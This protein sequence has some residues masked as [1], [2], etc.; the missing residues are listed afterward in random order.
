ML[1]D[2]KT[3]VFCVTALIVLPALSNGQSQNSGER[4]NIVL[5]NLDDADS[6]LFLPEMLAAFFPNM[7]N[8]ARNGLQFTNVHATTP[9]CAPS[10]A[11]LFRGQYAFNTGIKIN[12]PGSNIS[13]GFSGGYGEFVARGYHE[14]E[15]GVWM[16]NVGYRT[17]HVGKYHHHNFNFEVPPGWDDFRASLGAPYY[18]GSRFTNKNAPS[19]IRYTTEPDQYQTTIDGDEAVELIQQHGSGDQPF[20]LY[21]APIAPHAANSGVPEDMVEHQYTNFAASHV[22]PDSPDLYELDQSD[23]PRHLRIELEPDQIELFQRT[24]ISRLRA[25]KSVDDMVGRIVE[26]LEQAGVSDSTYI[27][28]TSDNGFQNGHHN[29]RGK[30]DPYHRTTNVP[31][32]VAGPGVPANRYADHLLAHIDLCP[33][34]LHLAQSAVPASVEARSFIPL[35]F[36]PDNFDEESWQDSIMIENWSN[37]P[38]FGKR[39]QHGYT[40]IR[41]HHEIFV[42]WAHGVYE[43]YDL[44]VDPYQLNNSY[45]SLSVQQRQDLKRSI[46]RFRDRAVEPITTIDQRF[47]NRIQNQNVRLRGYGEDD[48]GVLKTQVVVRSSSTQ[49]FWNGDTWQD[50]W[51][52]HMVNPRNRNQPLSIWNFRTRLTTETETGRDFLVFTYRSMDA[53][54]VFSNNVNFHVNVVDGKPPVVEFMDY[55]THR[56]VF[57]SNVILSGEYFDGVEFDRACMTVRKTG[58]DEYFNGTDFQVGRFEIP[59]ELISGTQWSLQLSLPAGRY[60]AGVKGFDVA[61]NRQHPA[62]ILRFRVDEE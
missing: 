5:I 8:M 32:I 19:G 16:K 31:L 36:N 43:Y 52:G 62:N 38:H 20:F 26:A 17:M 41:R 61:G 25:V 50:D 22:I 35:L 44:S 42:S 29:L 55:G 10:R 59:I 49:R 33:T 57:N 14:D 4:P 34:I 12:D 51:F 13:N 56:P 18:G 48:A 40:A 47:A 1:L 11:A 37:R 7:D 9:F 28:L 60:I 45:T 24:Y 15:L 39:I 2:L 46:R 3:V 58:T 30:I 23:K 27:L 6:D 53:S 21:V 54:N